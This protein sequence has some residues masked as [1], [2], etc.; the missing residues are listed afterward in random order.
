MSSSTDEL[1]RLPSPVVRALSLAQSAAKLKASRFQWNPFGG[2]PA[3]VRRGEVTGGLLPRAPLTVLLADESK[4]LFRDLHDP[5][6]S[7]SGMA[8][9]PTA[10]PDVLVLT[11]ANR[12]KLDV[13]AK[14]VPGEIWARIAAGTTKLVLDASG[15]GNP[16][17]PYTT[18][19]I[20]GF[21][22]GKGVPIER[23]ALVTQDRGYEAD[24]GDHCESLGLGRHRM[25]VWVYDSY[26]QRL[27]ADFHDHG[28]QL[29]DLR[30]AG[31]A[32]APRRRA[33]RFISLNNTIR[34]FRALFLLALLRDRLWDHGFISVG[35]LYDIDRQTLSRSKFNERL[36]RIPGFDD[37]VAELTP[38]VDQLEAR[39]PVHLGMDQANPAKFRKT[40]LKPLTLPEYQQS[41]FTIVPESDIS[42]RV[43]RITEKPFKPLLNFHPAIIL[44][45][46][47]TLDLLRAY[48][49]ET[50]PGFFDESYDQV[51]DPRARFDRVYAEVVRLCSAPE[52]ELDRLDAAAT[53]TAV[54]NAYWG[55]VELPRI[56]R[57]HIDP[58]LVDRLAAFADR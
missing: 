34:P 36:R 58:A 29:F 8:D 15:E 23:A 45:S 11:Q 49:F 2:D 20:H 37:L 42:D 44:G 56:F 22:R 5:R 52:A 31:Y 18:A 46:F 14:D 28:E 17:A 24:Y 12:L 26:V 54:F 6:V 13:S 21:L 57:T 30:L 40:L 10:P 48:G 1:D 35:D 19:T 53:E 7:V 9:Q 47:G 32:S 50:Y 16:H 39:S 41:W 25:E 38:L 4:T 27:F 43:H 33:R 51:A 3:G 55:M